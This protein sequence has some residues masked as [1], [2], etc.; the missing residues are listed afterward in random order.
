MASTNSWNPSARASF[1]SPLA[2]EHLQDFIYYLF[3][4]LLEE[5]THNPFK[6]GWLEVGNLARYLSP[7]PLSPPYPDLDFALVRTQTPRWCSCW[8]IRLRL[9]NPSSYAVSICISSS[10]FSLLHNRRLVLV[11]AIWR[12][13]NPWPGNRRFWQQLFFPIQLKKRH[14]VLTN[15]ETK[16]KQEDP[17]D[18]E[19]GVTNRAVLKGKGIGP[20]EVVKEKWKQINDHKEWVFF[21]WPSRY[22]WQRIHPP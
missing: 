12:L 22:C 15:L 9:I 17:D 21:I 18:A 3:M 5:S 14:R 16:I 13:E 4:G 20:A 11:N 10:N 6:F 2:L 19:D 7:S 1:T 8:L